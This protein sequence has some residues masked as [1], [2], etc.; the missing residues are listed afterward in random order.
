MDKIAMKYAVVSGKKPGTQTV[1]LHPVIVDRTTYYVNSTID[2]ALNAGYI[3]GQKDDMLGIIRGFFRACKELVDSG[4]AVN[5]ADWVRIHPELTGALDSETRQLSDDKNSLK[6][7]LT[8]LS[9]M[10][11]LSIDDF[12]WTSTEDTGKVVKVTSIL[13][14]GDNPN[15][16]TK[17]KDLFI[18]GRNLQFNASLGDTCTVE[19]DGCENPIS[20]TC[21]E[22]DY[23]H[24]KFSWSALLADLEDETPLTI[25]L[26]SRGGVS[27]APAQVIR[28][29]VTFNA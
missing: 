11:D 4:F 6:V 7:R 2:Y 1:V 27:G 24:I 5:L 28:R 19:W 8:P 29:V 3:R 21:S 23:A 18:G 20:L 17:T 25:K 14:V 13:G 26:T 15:E 9:E 22:S 16:W 10:K 12:S